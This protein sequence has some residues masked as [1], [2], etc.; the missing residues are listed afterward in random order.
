MLTLLSVHVISVLFLVLVANSA[1]T[2]GF[3]WSYTLLLL[4]PG[5]LPTCILFEAQ[6]G[7]SVLFGCFATPIK[8]QWQQ[9]A[10]RQG[11]P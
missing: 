7:H 1:P 8:V 4:S 3:Y 2:M 5:L 11:N 10:D 6:L 9:L